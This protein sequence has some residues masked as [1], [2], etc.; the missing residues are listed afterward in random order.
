M[1]VRGLRSSWDA[2][3]TNRCWRACG[4]LGPG[5]EATDQ[6]PDGDAEHEGGERHGDQEGPGE[7][8]GALVDVVE[9][10]G[11]MDDDVTAVDGG[12]LRAEEEPALS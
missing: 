7:G 9:G 5:D 12:T 11:D 10:G 3:A 4:R 6:E 1:R 2:S 8:G